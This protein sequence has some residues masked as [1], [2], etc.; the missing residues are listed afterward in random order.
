MFLPIMDVTVTPR[1]EGE[2]Y[3]VQMSQSLLDILALI[4]EFK[5]S[6]AWHIARFVSQKDQSK[7]LALK[8]RRMWQA[9]LLESLQI[10]AGTRLGMPVYYM[11]SKQ[12]LKTLAEQADYDKIRLKN[13]PTPASFISS[14]LFKHDAQIV[15]LAS[16]EAMNRTEKLQ[17]TFTGETG[18]M[19]RE[20]R[21]DK[22]IEVLTPDYIVDYTINGV[23][24]RVYSEFERTNKSA[25]AMIRKIERYR[26]YFWP[27]EEK[28]K[29]LRLVFQTA[30]MEE[31]F[32]L[33][34]LT[35]KPSL[36]QRLR[37][38]TTN[39]PLLEKPQQFLESVYAV[40]STVTFKREGRLVAEV[41]GRV[42]MFDFL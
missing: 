42:K 35:N 4:F 14:G 6:A 25:S 30:N 28:Y 36:L 29:T 31:A 2:Q 9:G 17:I 22:N 1:A 11:L 37:V 40:E 12:G 10:Y 32:W 26:Q 5:I 34:I 8:L 24:E 23:T 13:Y 27:G 7:Y 16:L 20:S 3:N 15:E 19:T 18:S 41:K 33:N 39:V 21:S 38:V